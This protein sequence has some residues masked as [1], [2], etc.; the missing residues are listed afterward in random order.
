MREEAG[1]E[2]EERGGDWEEKK[3]TR[4]LKG[5]GLPAGCV[6]FQGKEGGGTAEQVIAVTT[7][8]PIHSPPSFPSV[9]RSIFSPCHAILDSR[10]CGW[11][12]WERAA[13][14]KWAY[15]FFCS[16]STASVPNSGCKISSVGRLQSAWREGRVRERVQTLGLLQSNREGIHP[17]VKSFTGWRPSGFV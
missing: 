17:Y 8:P 5:M 3:P 10:C 15:F 7:S 2:G 14:S 13:L 16:C 4:C 9:R 11:I 12:N 6:C 1:W